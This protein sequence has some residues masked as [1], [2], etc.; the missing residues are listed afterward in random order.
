MAYYKSDSEMNGGKDFVVFWS[1]EV[2]R[3]G[4]NETPK[5]ILRDV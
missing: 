1:S 5:A 4:S 2:K 3:F